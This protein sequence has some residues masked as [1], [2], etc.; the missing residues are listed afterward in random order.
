MPRECKA[1]RRKSMVLNINLSG[2]VLLHLKTHLKHKFLD[3][4]L[5]V[6][7]G[8]QIAKSWYI[9]P[10]PTANINIH[11]C[12]LKSY[13]YNYIHNITI[14]DKNTLHSHSINNDFRSI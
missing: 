13:R 12:Q 9:F 5:L 8:Y 1:N 10:D 14:L 7:S 6:C 11:L 3:P 2:D 4:P